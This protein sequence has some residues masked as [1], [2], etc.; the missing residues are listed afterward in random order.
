MDGKY[1]IVVP[2]QFTAERP[3]LTFTENV[4]NSKIEKHP[5][6]CHLPGSTTGSS[7][8]HDLPSDLHSFAGPCFLMTLQ[9]MAEKQF[10]QLSLHITTFDDATV[11][12]LSWPHTLMDGVGVRAL[13]HNWSLVLNDREGDILDV[14]QED[15]L[16]NTE[17][18]SRRSGNDFIDRKQPTIIQQLIFAMRICWQRFTSPTLQERLIFLQEK[19][20]HK[21][22]SQAKHDLA[23]KGQDT[24]VTDG[25]ILAA[26]AARMLA[27]SRPGLQSITLMSM[28]NARFRLSI[29]RE[30]STEYI[31]NLL[32]MLQ[33]NL[34]AQ[35]ARD[36]IGLTALDHRTEV[37]KQASEKQIWN[38]FRIQREN[39]RRT[40]DLKVS[41]EDPYTTLVAYNNLTKLDFLRAIN[42]TSAV[43]Q[44][45]DNSKTRSNDIGTVLFFTP[46]GAGN[47]MQYVETFQ[48][49]SKDCSGNYQV[50]AKLHPKMWARV[51]KELD[52]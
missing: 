41:F 44:Q 29:L 35:L 4:F 36:N 18:E 42:F 43:L 34:P 3:A 24:F 46:L 32:L 49:L 33:V 39:I 1:E 19:H 30:S 16:G 14:A 50:L 5:T 27:L 38:Y 20:F 7:S 28:V 6:G 12:V 51:E 15:A 9:E 26:W 17:S 52:S 40:G 23:L 10:P 21:F 37:S 2:K 13:L 45:G 25:D 47:G 48:V 31:Q 22:K 11:I 8:M